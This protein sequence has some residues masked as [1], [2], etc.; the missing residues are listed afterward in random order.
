[1]EARQWSVDID[2]N[3]Q[4]CNRGSPRNNYL[5]E[6]VEIVFPID[7]SIRRSLVMTIS[8]ISDVTYVR[9]ITVIQQPLEQLKIKRPGAITV[10]PRE[11][12]TANNYS[13][14]VEL[15]NGIV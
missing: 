12:D 9:A 6:V 10:T 13:T 8:L 7:P 3:Y 1:M 15:S 5:S 14:W 4:W 11:T 2:N